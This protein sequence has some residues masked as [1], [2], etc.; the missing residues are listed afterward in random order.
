MFGY[1]LGACAVVWCCT[2][3]DTQETLYTTQ[4]EFLQFAKLLVT[5][6]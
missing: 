1:G 5:A 4:S 6:M 3:L 2:L